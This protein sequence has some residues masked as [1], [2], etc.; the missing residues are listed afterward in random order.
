MP[1]R[2]HHGHVLIGLL[3]RKRF[4]TYLA[5]DLL[6]VHICSIHTH[7]KVKGRDPQQHHGKGVYAQLPVPLSFSSSNI[8]FLRE[9]RSMWMRSC[10]SVS[11]HDERLGDISAKQFQSKVALALRCNLTKTKRRSMSCSRVH[12]LPIQCS[13]N[14]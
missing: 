2:L 13:T 7:Q 3:P 11:S 1:A 4:P 5:R 10:S 12:S 14:L 9:H 6:L 8:C